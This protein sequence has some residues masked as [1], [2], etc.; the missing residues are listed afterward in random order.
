MILRRLATSIRKQD[1][2]TVIIETL[3]VVFGVFIGLQVN[4]WNEARKDRMEAETSRE[5]LIAEL[6]ADLDA[7]AVRRQWYE[8]VQEAALRADEALRSDPPETIDET[9]GFVLDSWIAGGEWPFEPSAQI[10][11]ELQNSGD[12]DLIASGSMQRRLRDYYEDSVNE[13]ETLMI[14]QSGYRD[15]SRQLI[16]GRVGMLM[17]DCLS[18]APSPEPSQPS[19]NPDTFYENCPPPEDI[20]LLLRSAKSLR[21]S[22]T[23]RLQLNFQLSKLAWLPTFLDYLDRQATSL[24][25]DLE[26]EQ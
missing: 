19:A 15:L 11:S 1:W 14:F 13:I 16:E 7:F 10:Y 8:E 2:F 24:V 9:W 25:S 21:E 22:E 17:I 4:N 26:T 12:L 6:Q 3:I 18:S 5:R 20:A 23:L